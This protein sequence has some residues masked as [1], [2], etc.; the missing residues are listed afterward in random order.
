MPLI[1][2]HIDNHNGD[3]DKSLAGLS[4]IG[5]VAEDLR[6]LSLRLVGLPIDRA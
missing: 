2:P 5:S 3:P 1:E 4:S 6:S